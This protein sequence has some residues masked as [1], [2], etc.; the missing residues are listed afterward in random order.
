M[1]YQFHVMEILHEPPILIPPAADAVADAMDI[2]AVLETTGV[3]D[4]DPISIVDFFKC[5]SFP[6]IGQLQ[7]AAHSKNEDI[8]SVGLP[9]IKC[10]HLP[11]GTK[12]LL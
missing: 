1:V 12:H 5:E 2:V 7:D 9:Y 8:V 10:I 4:M 6:E 11:H 3:I